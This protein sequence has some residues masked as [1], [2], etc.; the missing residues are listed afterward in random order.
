MC[1]RM[2]KRT[3]LVRPGGDREPGRGTARERRGSWSPGSGTRSEHRGEGVGE[4]AEGRSR[5]RAPLSNWSSQSG[6]MG[7]GQWGEREG[8]ILFKR[9]GECRK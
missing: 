1:L 9:R 4:K 5:E 6:S 3:C 8:G 7:G 2:K